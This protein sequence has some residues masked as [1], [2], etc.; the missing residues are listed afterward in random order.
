MK[1]AF[2]QN[3]IRNLCTKEK[4]YAR[5]KMQMAMNCMQFYNSLLRKYKLGLIHFIFRFLIV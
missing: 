3:P 5:E 1:F 2:P 4:Q